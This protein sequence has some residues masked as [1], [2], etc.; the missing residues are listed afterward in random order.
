M[1]V[2]FLYKSV[3]SVNQQTFVLKWRE[4]RMHKESQHGKIEN[5]AGSVWLSLFMDGTVKCKLM[6]TPYIQYNYVYC[7][8]TISFQKWKCSKEW[9]KT[10]KKRETQ[11]F[12]TSWK[13]CK[14]L[15]NRFNDLLQDKI[16]NLSLYRGHN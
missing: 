2:Y 14:I 5:V 13:P 16:T 9:C 10:S 6:S 12:M 3:W 7:V 8:N 11:Y 15:A 1:C 4:I